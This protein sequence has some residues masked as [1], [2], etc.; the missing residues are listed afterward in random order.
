MI[1]L[2]VP[3]PPASRPLSSKMSHTMAQV[4]LRSLIQAAALTPALRQEWTKAEARHD[5]S[6]S[7]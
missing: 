1:L 6:G 2:L 5:A 4:T 3:T 7:C